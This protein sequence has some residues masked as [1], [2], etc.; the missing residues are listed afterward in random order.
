MDIEKKIAESK[1]YNLEVFE[2]VYI[3]V[4]ASEENNDLNF[5]CFYFE[6]HN[7]I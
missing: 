3:L 6:K 5:I 4:K 7:K 2:T 1:Y